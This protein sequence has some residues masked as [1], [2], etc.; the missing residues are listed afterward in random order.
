MMMRKSGSGPFSLV[1]VKKMPLGINMSSLYREWG[2]LCSHRGEQTGQVNYENFP[3]NDDISGD[4]QSVDKSPLLDLLVSVKHKSFLGLSFLLGLPAGHPALIGRHR[5]FPV[6]HKAAE[7]W[8]QHMQQALDNV[9]DIDKDSKIKMN[10]FRHTAFFLVA[11]DELKN[12]NEGIACKHTA[13]K[14]AA[15]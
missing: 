11:G 5:P 9:T 7:R 2:L 13:N 4:S 14:P 6:T 1:Q 12:Q 3:F 15:E 10:F 8:L